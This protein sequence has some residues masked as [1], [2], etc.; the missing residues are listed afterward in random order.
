[1]NAFTTHEQTVF[2]VRVPD[3][4]FELAFDILADIVWQPAFRPNDVESE[5]QVILEEI[6]MRDDTPDDLV[7]ELFEQAMFPR[8]PLGREVLGSDE[9]HQGDDT[10][11]DRRVSRRA[12]P[13][14]E[15]RVRG[16][17]QP[18][19]RR[20]ARA[21]RAAVPARH[22]NSARTASPGAARAPSPSPS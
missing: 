20:R 8:H 19:P 18:R 14:V 15:H 16:G 4:H 13:A 1:M 21:R 10:R 12:L 11:R 7:H 3:T 9:Q 22:R 6:G 2:Y 5:R 17:R